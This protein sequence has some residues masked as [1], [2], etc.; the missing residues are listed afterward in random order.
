MIRDIIINLLIF[1]IIESYSY[2]SPKTNIIFAL[3]SATYYSMI[4]GILIACRIYF[5]IHDIPI[6]IGIADS[7]CSI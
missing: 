7:I 5:D 4:F 1:D 2:F 6:C 3:L